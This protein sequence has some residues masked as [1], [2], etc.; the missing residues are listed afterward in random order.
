VQK[1]RRQGSRQLRLRGSHRQPG[2][3]VAQFSRPSGIGE[4]NRKPISHRGAARHSRN[5]KNIHH[6]V[7]ET[8]RKTNSKAKPEHTEAAE[9]TERILAA[10]RDSER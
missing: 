6:R 3:E 5:Q 8:L 4:P 9:A 1:H 7:T 10:R 2:P